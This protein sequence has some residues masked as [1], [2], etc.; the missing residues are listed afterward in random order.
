MC[1]IATDFQEG[2]SVFFQNPHTQQL[3]LN[4]IV[5]IEKQS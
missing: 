3:I 5:Q 2:T 4:K 1:F